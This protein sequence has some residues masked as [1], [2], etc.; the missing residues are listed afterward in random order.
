[1]NEFFGRAARSASAVL[2]S[3]WSFTAAIVVV[4]VWATLGPAY[5]FSDTWQLV[6][7]T[8][9]SIVT[10]L[11]VF[12]IQNT[13]NRDSKALHLKIDELLYAMKEART[14]L[15]V[16][17]ELSDA[18]IEKLEHDFRRVARREARQ[19]AREET[20][21]T[22]AEEGDEEAK[23]ESSNAKKKGKGSKETG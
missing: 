11:M 21:A 8:G 5:H 23:A 18:E 16:L 10:F 20:R 13:Q 4:L 19:E 6:I 22:L 7:N 1:M 12:L 9:T 3:A 15:V 17:D 2:G 14:G